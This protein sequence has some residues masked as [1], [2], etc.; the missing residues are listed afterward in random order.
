MTTEIKCNRNRLIVK[1]ATSVFTEVITQLELE[2]LV[3]YVAD[4]ENDK[5]TIQAPI[6]DEETFK[7]LSLNIIK[8]QVT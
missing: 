3:D 2:E 8:S 5:V 4:F 7:Q 6:H 1:C